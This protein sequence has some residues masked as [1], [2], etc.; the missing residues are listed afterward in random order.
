[1]LDFWTNFNK[2]LIH[3]FDP[4]TSEHILFLFAVVV[5]YEFYQW[6]KLFVLGFLIILGHTLALLF[7][8]LANFNVNGSLISLLMSTVILGTAIY[9]IITTGT[10]SKKSG[11]TFISI[12]CLLYGILHGIGYTHYFNSTLKVNPSDKLLPLFE[13]SLG[14]FLSVFAVV[15]V[16][17]LI[18]YVIQT[19]SKF[20]KRDWILLVSAFIV[21]II[22]PLLLQ[23]NFWIL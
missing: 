11:L 7:S 18:G 16:I 10:S 20:S 6:K 12:L 19:L 13:F 2:G 14:L 1:M 5:S 4:L 15:V 3:M 17:L 8:V 21:G 22:L 9:T 23:N